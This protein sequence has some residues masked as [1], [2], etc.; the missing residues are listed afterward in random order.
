MEI[1]KVGLLACILVHLGAICS[2]PLN[3][4]ILV[5]GSGSNMEAIFRYF[6]QPEKKGLI[7]PC[8]VISNKK[9]AYALKRAR[10]EVE[11]TFKNAVPT[12][13]IPSGIRNTMSTEEKAETRRQYAQKLIECLEKH[14]VTKKNGLICG[15]GFMVILHK[16]FLNHFENQVISIH[17]T[18]LPS[19]AGDRGIKDAF[20]YGVKTSGPTVHI[21]DEGMDTGPIIMQNPFNVTNEDTLETFEEKTHKA[22]HEMYPWVI[23]QF[24]HGNVKIE[25]RSEQGGSKRFVVIPAFKK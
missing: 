11:T 2:E 17:P 4:G 13:Y 18:L 19:F 24:A 14:G 22:E 1:S 20:A 6:E 10:L 16:D 9:D 25:D 3:V 7:K 8:V 12:E 21:V 5:S 15:A 23:E